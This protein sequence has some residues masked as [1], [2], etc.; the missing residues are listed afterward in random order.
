MCGF[1]K[2][3]QVRNRMDLESI[4]DDCYIPLMFYPQLS[5]AVEFRSVEVER[6][7]S[8]CRFESN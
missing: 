8:V 3:G 5:S 7:C 2:N 1:P 4:L 6:Y